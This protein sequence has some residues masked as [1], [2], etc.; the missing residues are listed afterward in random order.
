MGSTRLPGKVM[1]EVNGKPLIE[2]LLYRLSRSKK[3]DKLILATSE[4][5]EN[6]LLVKTV[7]KLGFEVF[8]GSE[9]DVLDRYYE[10][11][12]LFRPK[13]VVRITGDCPIIDPQLVDEV[14]SLYLKNNA[15]YVSN[16]EPSTFPDG[17][18]TEVFSFAALEM[19]REQATKSFEREHVTPFIRTNG[20]FQRFNYTSEIDLF[21]ERR[22]V[23]NP[24]DFSVIENILN[25]FA[26]N[27]DFTW[28]EVLDLKQ[29]RPEYFEAN[30][31]IRRNEGADLGTG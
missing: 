6:D 26:P 25:Y 2:I 23:D 19:A 16:T 11:A 8:R 14:I 24:E 18:D 13:A 10:A 7:K 15:D 1:K 9:D 28:K 20:Q 3:I 4:N 29:S 31:S 21:G 22:V 27:L 12:K 17:L 5:T 30:Q